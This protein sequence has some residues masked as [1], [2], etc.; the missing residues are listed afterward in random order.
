VK[1][2]EIDSRQLPNRD[3]RWSDA[4]EVGSLTFLENVK[5]D[6]GFKAVYREVTYRENTTSLTKRTS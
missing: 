4:I 6:L 5:S 3:E 1:P 2:N